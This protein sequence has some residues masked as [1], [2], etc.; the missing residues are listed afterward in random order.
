MT[1][2]EAPIELKP[3]TGTRPTNIVTIDIAQKNALEVRVDRSKQQAATLTITNDEEYELRAEEL[4]E[5]ARLDK[6]IEKLFKPQNEF[7]HEGHKA[8]KAEE[9]ALRDPLKKVKDIYRRGLGKYQADLEQQRRIEREMV[10]AQQKAEMDASALEIAQGLEESGD[11]QGAEAVIAQA[12]KMQPEVNVESFA[13]KVRGTATR[14]TWKYEVL[15]E[16]LIP[17]KYWTRVL[18]DAMI[19]NEVEACKELTNIPGI[20]ATSETKVS[21]RV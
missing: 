8:S 14:T 6:D 20:R 5:V 12:A 3:M 2:V 11:K 18:N 21:A 4:K 17:E 13:P 16:N 10:L 1:T 15:D 7:W 9:N 19:Q